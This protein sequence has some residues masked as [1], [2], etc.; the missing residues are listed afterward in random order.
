VGG[1]LSDE[2]DLLDALFDDEPRKGAPKAIRDVI[3]IDDEDLGEEEPSGGAKKAWR[4]VGKRDDETEETPPTLIEAEAGRHMQLANVMEELNR[5]RRVEAVAAP[6]APVEHTRV[7]PVAPAPLPP[8]VAPAPVAPAPVAPA[9]VAPAPSPIPL[10]GARTS[11][12]LRVQRISGEHT[13]VAYTPPA[14]PA[15]APS[16]PPPPELD[17]HDPADD[18]AAP[19]FPPDLPLE[20]LA[21]A[22]ERF[23]EAEE[24]R[25]R[26]EDTRSR[27]WP[28][29]HDGPPALVPVEPAPASMKTVAPPPPRQP[30]DGTIAGLPLRTVALLLLVVLASAGLMALL[31]SALQEDIARLGR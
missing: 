15:P 30:W 3:L 5:V 2:D 6:R 10:V 17:W 8:P 4:G 23:P 20:G 21:G 27:S 24:H 19:A 12:E 31:G 22:V 25:V 7:E 13:P 14:P 26:G 9:P 28:R 18:A 29:A 16:P 11:G 1:K